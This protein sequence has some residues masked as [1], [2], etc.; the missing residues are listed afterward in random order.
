MIAFG[1][2]MQF[3]CSLQHCW[4]LVGARDIWQALRM[5]IAAKN[6]TMVSTPPVVNGMNFKR[7]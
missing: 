5:R 3:R 4:G 6:A 1:Y 2:T 7:R